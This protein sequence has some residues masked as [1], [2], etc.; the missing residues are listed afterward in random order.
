M[1][2]VGKGW[3]YESYRH[4]LAAK[5][6]KTALIKPSDFV[7][8]SGIFLTGSVDDVALINKKLPVNG[9]GVSFAGKTKIQLV[10]EHKD[11]VKQFPGENPRM[12]KEF[13]RFRQQDPKKYDDFRTKKIGDNEFI[14]GHNKKS[15]K[16]ELQSI[17][18]KR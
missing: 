15:G 12:T 14:Y 6:I 13:A 4:S 18:I 7:K 3:H 11:I 1:S 17:L 10:K 16:W 2:Y 5:K 9:T 8:W